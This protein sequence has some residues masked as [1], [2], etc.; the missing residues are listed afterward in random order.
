MAK[1]VKITLENLLR[2]NQVEI[3]FKSDIWITT[4][5]GTFPLLQT[6]R[7]VYFSWMLKTCRIPWR[8]TL[9][10][11]GEPGRLYFLSKFCAPTEI[12]KKTKTKT[13]YSKGELLKSFLIP[14]LL[15]R[16][17]YA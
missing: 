17:L 3:S 2:I 13:I 14:K 5:Y 1:Q 4:C 7:A 15:M 11:Y 16:G 9:K 12:T 6:E 8:E 10:L